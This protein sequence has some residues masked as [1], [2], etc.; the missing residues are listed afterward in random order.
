LGLLREWKQSRKQTYSVRQLVCSM[1][2]ILFEQYKPRTK[3]GY[4]LDEVVSAVQKTIRRGDEESALYFSLELFPKYSKYLWKRLQVI[5]VEDI[6]SPM[7]AVVVGAMR[8][9]FFWNNESVK[10]EEDY[11]NRIFITK[12]VLFLCREVKSREADH[13]QHF[14]DKLSEGKL[15][16]IPE[17]AVDVHTKSGRAKGKTKKD[18][19]TAEQKALNPKGKDEY[20]KKLKLK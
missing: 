3:N 7:A 16:K 2:D 10:N 13:C 12:A 6:A 14:I 9:A 19:F 18:F 15:R 20:F 11:K 5:S 8:G 1:Q 17:F 4:M